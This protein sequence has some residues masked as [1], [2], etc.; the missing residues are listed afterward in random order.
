MKKI[1]NI[2][3]I[4][5]KKD[6]RNFLFLIIIFIF[7]SISDLIGVASI[8][9]FLSVLS[10]SNLINENEYLIL[11]NSYLN[12]ETKGFIIFLGF[13]TLTV[14]IFNQSIRVF[15]AWFSSLFFKKYSYNLSQQ[16]YSYFL[17]SCV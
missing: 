13:M 5:K 8:Y 11:I 12:F 2:W 6:K 1:I 4:S 16:V 17:S 7:S 14:L 9:P 10:N 3:K 15:A